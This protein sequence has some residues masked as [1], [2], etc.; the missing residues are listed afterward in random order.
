MVFGRNLRDYGQKHRNPLNFPQKIQRNRAAARSQ[1]VEKNPAQRF[2]DRPRIAMEESMAFSLLQEV[3]Q[4]FLFVFH[5]SV[6]DGSHQLV[7]RLPDGGPL[8]SQRQKISALNC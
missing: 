6:N 1:I 2:F 7:Q 3:Q 8:K 5:L 4:G